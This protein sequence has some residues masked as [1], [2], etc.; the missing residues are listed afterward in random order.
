MG[1]IVTDLQRCGLKRKEKVMVHSSLYS[2]GVI[3]NGPETFVSALK[4]VIS[5]EGMI[6]MPTFPQRNMY[7]Y[8]NSYD[9]FDVVAS[10]SR[11]GAITEYFRKGDDTYR[12]LHPTH[13]VAAW[14]KN[15][16]D[17]CS[18]HEKSAAPFDKHSPYKKIIDANFKIML[19]GIDFEH[20]TVCRA[21]EDL[22]P[23]IA[24]N[25]Y[26]DQNYIV[27][28]RDYGGKLV[29]VETKCHSPDYRRRR[30]NM[31]LYEHLQNRMTVCKLGNARTIVV[32]AHDIF[33]TQVE[34]AKR[35]IFGYREV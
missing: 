22:R 25:P 16:R 26:L 10:P 24:P 14:G 12:S 15:A 20:M 34:L 4:K 2:I 5:G 23:D 9:L 21:F 32:Y 35:G 3:E 6:V 17:F 33:D 13:P 31:Y 19:I 18:G 8:L 28:V 7:N 29:K 27:E 11:N 1:N 30:F